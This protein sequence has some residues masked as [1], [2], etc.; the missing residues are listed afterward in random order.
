MAPLRDARGTLRYF[1]GAQVDVSGLA[2]EC[3]DLEA[4]Q[5]MLADQNEA[6]D[7]QALVE[8]EEF[9]QLSQMFNQVELDIVRKAGGRMHEEHIE[10]EERSNTST[11]W[12]RP[13]LLL[14]N[15]SDE[16]EREEFRKVKTSEK[17]LDA[18]SR[19][20]GKLVGIY[21]HVRLNSFTFL[22]NR[23][24]TSILHD[25]WNNLNLTASLVSTGST[26]PFA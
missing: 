11:S 25:V 9:E 4:L 14:K 3:T 10:D 17:P 13:R 20:H 5:K 26:V 8:K 24:D 18:P 6:S 12:H 23:V 22:Q 21:S 19:V 7:G 1:I 16:D 15:P 2:K